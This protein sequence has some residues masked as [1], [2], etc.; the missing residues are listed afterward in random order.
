MHCKT[1]KKLKQILRNVCGKT[2]FFFP[3]FK[4]RKKEPDAIGLRS[5]IS[6]W[7]IWKREFFLK[8]F[9]QLLWEEVEHLSL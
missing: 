6:T 1:K 9:S 3:T 2:L 8:G 5:A 7:L 4:A